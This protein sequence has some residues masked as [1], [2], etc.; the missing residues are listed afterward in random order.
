MQHYIALQSGGFREFVVF[1]RNS[2][3]RRPIRPATNRR[4]R[5]LTDPFEGNADDDCR[6]GHV[7]IA[8]SIDVRTHDRLVPRRSHDVFECLCDFTSRLDDQDYW[9]HMQRVTAAGVQTKCRAQRG[10]QLQSRSM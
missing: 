6:G 8:D 7:E 9:T 3:D 4:V 2:D 1:P 5:R 10:D